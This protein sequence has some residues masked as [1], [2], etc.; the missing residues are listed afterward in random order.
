MV[1]KSA[2]NYS[3]NNNCQEAG[4]SITKPSKTEPYDAND[5]NVMKY[6]LLHANDNV[7]NMICYLK[8]LINYP[9]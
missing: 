5:D 6:E 3:G 9:K 8:L 7:W 4:S 1:L 2:E